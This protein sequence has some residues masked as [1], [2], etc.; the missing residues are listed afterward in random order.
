MQQVRVPIN[1]I[2][3]SQLHVCHGLKPWHTLIIT[4]SM[5]F[6]ENY[7][8][9]IYNR[10]NNK[11]L[12]FFNDDNYIFFLKKV[13]KFIYPVCDIINYCLMPNHFHL[14]IF[15]NGKTIQTKKNGLTEKNVLSEAFR[16]VLSSYSQAINK[17]NNTTGSLFQQN[18]KSKCLND[19]SINYAT[20]CFYYIHQN[21]CKPGLARFMEEW[22]YSSFKDYAGLRNGTLCNKQLAVELLDLDMDNFYADS[23][24][25]IEEDK[26]KKIF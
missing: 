23:Y 5:E 7:L 16:N 18:T 21:P 19:G 1:V 2:F 15:A 25:I 24:K 3:N 26:S 12:I 17:Q 9:H 4:S 10:G 11:Q 8:Y 14:L 6:Q 20:T 13:R 22:K